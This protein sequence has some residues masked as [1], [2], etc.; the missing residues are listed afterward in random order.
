VSNLA[1]VLTG[2]STALE[3]FETTFQ[4][5]LNGDGVITIANG[6][7]MELTGSYAGEIA[8]GGATGTLKIDHTANFTGTVGGQLAIG[9]Q[10]DLADVTAGAGATLHYSGN[11][12][13]GTLTVSDGTHTASLA[14]LG[15]YSLANFTASSDGHGGTIVVDPPITAAGASDTVNQQVALLS[16]YMASELS[17]APAVADSTALGSIQLGSVSQ[18]ATPIANQQH[19]SMMS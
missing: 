12:S 8:F 4:Q 6:Q 11:N 5:D 9:D 17:T 13:P 14:L 18:L 3:S 10:I 2:N 15:N 19:T 1:P 7:S 16:Q